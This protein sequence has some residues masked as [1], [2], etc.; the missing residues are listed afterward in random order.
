MK[1]AF[2]LIELLVVVLIIGIL[3]GIALP[4]YQK[5]ID[6][7]EMAGV[8]QTFAAIDEAMRMYRL[9]TGE[10]PT[11]MDQLAIKVPNSQWRYSLVN[12]KTEQESCLWPNGY[13]TQPRGWASIRADKPGLGTSIGYGAVFYSMRGRTVSTYKPGVFCCTFGSGVGV[14]RWKKFCNAAKMGSGTAG[15]CYTG[16]RI[17]IRLDQ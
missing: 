10:W 5:S 3:A 12:V 11:T 6:R 8:L 16:S 13:R 14:E 15:A 9:E 4:N 1:R 17:S 7:A 2:T